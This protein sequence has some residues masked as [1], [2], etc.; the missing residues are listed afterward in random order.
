VR[1]KT[2]YTKLED[3]KKKGIKFILSGVH[4]QPRAALEKS[5]FLKEIGEENIATKLD[6]ALNIAR[7]ILG[8]PKIKRKV[9]FVQI[10]S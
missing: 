5:G 4:A 2:C 3:C 7:G 10:V 9:S 8:K 6:D 1:I